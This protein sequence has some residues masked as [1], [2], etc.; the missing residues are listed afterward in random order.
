MATWAAQLILCAAAALCRGA[1]G[2]VLTSA[3]ADTLLAVSGDVVIGAEYTAIDDGAFQ[4][5]AVT[6]VTFAAGGALTRIGDRAFM[7]CSSLGGA[8]EL[9]ASLETIGASA[10]RATAVTSVTFVTFAAGGALTS[11]GDHAVRSC[12]SLGGALELPASLQTIGAGAFE[13]TALISLTFAVGSVLATIGDAAFQDCSSLTGATALPT[14]LLTVGTNVFKNTGSL[15]L[16]VVCPAIAAH[17]AATT[18]C[19]CAV[20]AIAS[21]GKYMPDPEA[22]TDCI[23]CAGGKYTDVTGSDEASDCIDCAGGKYLDVLGSDDAADCIGCVLGKYIDVTLASTLM[24]LGVMKRQTALNVLL[25]N[26]L[27]WL[28]AMI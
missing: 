18:S 19:D 2:V 1:A 4:S 3:L 11:I 9:P 22:T 21:A 17:T 15:S 6:S 23:D 7:D 8:L 25:D 14:S 13:F 20:G 16:K 26:I 28:G 24:E 10:F 27:T 12:S 5:T